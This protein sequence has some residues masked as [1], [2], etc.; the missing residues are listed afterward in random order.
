MDPR[1]V[2][3]G[4]GL[5]ARIRLR[6]GL[7]FALDLALVIPPGRTVALLGPNG[8]GKSTTVAAL[9]GLLRLD[10]GWI[11]LD[12]ETLD[13][14]GAARYRAP[15]ERHVGVVFQDY[16]LFGH[17]TVAENIAFGPRSR[18]MPRAEAATRA[19]AWI[20]RLGLAGLADRRPR[21][22]SGGQAQRVALA[23]ALVT[24]PRLLLL[25]EPLAALDVQT[26]IELR[27]TL[28]EHLA[29]FGGP[30]LLITH[31]P[32]EAFLLGDE[33]HILEDGAVTQ[34]GT[35]DEIRRSP[36]TPYVAGLTGANLV[37]GTASNGVIVTGT[38]RLHVADGT[39]SGPV[40]AIIR[41]ESVGV[42]LA[43][44]EGSPRNAWRTSIELVEALGDRV[45]LQTGSPLPL[46]VEVT[47]ESSAALGLAPG[48]EVWL[49]LKA[50]EIEVEPYV[51]PRVEA[52]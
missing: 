7:T 25:D 2:I 44:P 50:T 18:G 8:A 16:L 6:R 45:R 34:S 37:V 14:P 48:L 15:E 17:L 3:E 43:R 24:E 9:A 40:L 20:E 38:H 33:I 13:E 26:R 35:A 36:R 19:A 30:R 52:T 28:A 11:R 49:S 5:E 51:P 27:R 12:G 1:P 23:R 22:L 46:S 42:H 31:D 29:A 39:L 4:T 21:S 32:T 10:D 47:G 41:A